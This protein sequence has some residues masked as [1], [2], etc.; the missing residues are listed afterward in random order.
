MYSLHCA[1]NGA[2][3]VNVPAPGC[4]SSA[5]APPRVARYR[6]SLQSTAREPSSW[7]RRPSVRAMTLSPSRMREIATACR[8]HPMMS[9]SYPPAMSLPSPTLTPA[10]SASRRGNGLAEK[11]AFDSGQWAIAVPNRATSASEGGSRKVQ[12]ACTVRGVSRRDCSAVVSVCASCLRESAHFSKDLHV[13]LSTF[14]PYKV[15]LVMGLRHMALDTE[16]LC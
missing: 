8:M 15:N 2:P 16:P 14:P 3:T 13:R 1:S 5:T 12:C 11:Y 4:K 6:A 7:H 9:M 10:W